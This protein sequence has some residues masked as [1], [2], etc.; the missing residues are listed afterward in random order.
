MLPVISQYNIIISHSPEPG[1]GTSAG[2]GDKKG[3]CEQT[4]G[5]D[6]GTKGASGKYP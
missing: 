6:E 1:G 4:R 3:D 2:P 5:K